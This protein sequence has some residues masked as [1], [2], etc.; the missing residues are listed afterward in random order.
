MKSSQ[1]AGTLQI[2]CVSQL[3]GINSGYWAPFRLAVSA[4]LEEATTPPKHSSTSPRA[5]ASQLWADAEDESGPS[6]RQQWAD[7]EDNRVP[8]GGAP[9]YGSPGDYPDST[10]TQ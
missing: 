3:G 6:A 2:N 4:M 9:G 8:C 10:D 5:H 1:P 7:V